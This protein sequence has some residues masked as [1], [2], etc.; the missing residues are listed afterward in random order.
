MRIVAIFYFDATGNK[1]VQDLNFVSFFNRSSVSELMHEYVKGALATL[2]D[3]RKIFEYPQWQLV[4]HRVHDNSAVLIT[5]NEYPTSVS[6]ELLRKVHEC[7]DNMQ[8]IL[9]NSQN[10]WTVTPTLRE[11]VVITHEKFES[12]DTIIIS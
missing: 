7:P 12:K 8:Y 11:T 9:S 1:Y 2:R 10:P 6:F 5:D 3:H 4:C